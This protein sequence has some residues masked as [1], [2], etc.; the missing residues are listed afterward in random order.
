MIDSL[1]LTVNPIRF[2][3]GVML[4]E[5]SLPGNE[6]TA[7]G[8]DPGVNFGMTIINREYV[9]I[10]YGKLPTDKRVGYRGIN[11]YNYIMNSALQMYTSVDASVRNNINA[12]VEGA[13]YRDQ[14]GQVTLEEVRFGFFFALYEIGFNVSIVPP[15]TIRK[16]ALGHGRATVGEL[17]PNLNHNACDS[18]G[19]AFYALK[20]I[21]E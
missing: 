19:A 5:A 15:A 17:Y 13:A 8:I 2:A 7:I 20:E 16:G 11:A 10:F 21:N 14:F 1:K 3:K 12:V 18:I 6:K 4:V 9:Q